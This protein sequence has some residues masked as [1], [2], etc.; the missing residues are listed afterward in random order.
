MIKNLYGED[1]KYQYE[2]QGNTRAPYTISEFIDIA[3][4]VDF[5]DKNS[6]NSKITQKIENDFFKLALRKKE[7]FVEGIKPTRPPKCEIFGHWNFPDPFLSLINDLYKT[8]E[9]LGAKIS[10]NGQD[11]L[12]GESRKISIVFLD[13]NSSNPKLL[14]G[15]FD[16]EIQMINKRS[17]AITTMT[18][19]Q[20]FKK[21]TN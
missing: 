17:G 6:T 8:H 20:E 4:K 7:K 5:A 3:Q 19:T 16:I 12:Y 21:A 9:L 10:Q 18:R 14:D 11:I 13:F 1:G 2:V 15:T